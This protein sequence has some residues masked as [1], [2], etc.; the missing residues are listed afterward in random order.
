MSGRRE[1]DAMRTPPP[2]FFVSVASKGVRTDV[3]LDVSLL[4]ATLTKV[5]ASVDFKRVRRIPTGLLGM[6]SGE[7]RKD[8]GTAC[9]S[10]WTRYRQECEKGEDRARRWAA[11]N[12][13]ILYE[14][15][16]VCQG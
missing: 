12:I 1:E 9:G 16:N 5:P 7:G 13:I 14:L 10:R 4:D 15:D 2:W 8:V 11:C 6:T 3:S